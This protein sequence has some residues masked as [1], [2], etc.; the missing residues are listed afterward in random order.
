M[1]R[2]QIDKPRRSAYIG[3]VKYR[4]LILSV[5]LIPALFAQDKP[6]EVLAP[7]YETPEPV[8]ERMLQLGNL[9]AGEKMADLGSGDGRIV[10]RAAIKYK[11]DATGVEYDRALVKQSEKRISRLK[12]SNSAHIIE[13]D[14]LRQDYSSFDLLTV[15]LLPV[16]NE[17]LIPLLEKQLKPGAR[18]VSHNTPLAPWTPV[19]VDD[20][21]NDGEGHSHKLY[22]Y[23]R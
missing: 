14:L 1:T 4:R 18:V 22:L 12:L 5:A 13:G 10:I 20:I 2:L 3:R 6:I 19:K 21:P 17:K 23:V 11:A 8:V 9:R 16:A 15:Y 7:Y